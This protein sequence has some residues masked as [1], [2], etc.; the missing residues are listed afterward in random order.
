M[1]T[2]TGAAVIL[3]TNT[4]KTFAAA[5]FPF[6]DADVGDTL[7]AIKVTSLPA[8]TL[9][10]NGTPITS[11][12]SADIPV[13]S[14]ATL[15]YTPVTGYN[16]ADTFNFQVS[17]GVAFSADATMAVTITP[18]ILVRNGSFETPANQASPWSSFASPWVLTN[19]PAGSLS[20]QQIKA[21]AGGFFTSAPD[22]LW[23]ALINGDDCP[24]TAPLTQSLGVS[25]TAGDTLTV[26]FQSGRQLGQVGGAGVAYFD[27]A[28]TQYT[29]AFD[30][31]ALTA[32]AWQLT[33]LT[34]TITNSGNLT[35]G[36]YGTTGH[37]LNA[38]IDQISN[39][40]ATAGSGG[41]T[42]TITG[43]AT[44]AVFTTTY[45]TASAA[46][47]FAIAGTNLTA[48]ITATAPT[49]FEVSS[50]GTNYASTATFTQTGG[51]ASGTLDVRLA[52][53][54][55]V[56]GTHDG[57]TIVL[58]ST[59]ATS[60][61]VTTA[62]SG[63]VVSKATPTATLAVSNSPATYTGSAQAA[64]VGIT[65]SVPVGGSVTNISTGGA[66]SQTAAGTYAVTAD[67]VPADTANY[68][69]LTGLAAGDFVISPAAQNYT[70]WATTNGMTGGPSHVG[71]DGLTN[72]LVY[73]LNLKTNGGNGSPGT[74][75]G[76]SLSFAKRADAVTNNDVT[77]AIQISADLGVVDP[78]TT[79]TTGV[80][81]T[82]S[83]IS[84][85]MTTMGGTKHFARLVV[86]QK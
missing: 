55:T 2:S 57:Q 34:H 47:T 46:Q 56:S 58:S 78:W 71:H 30:T 21:V 43:A 59:G 86:T 44:A 14:I 85:D 12:P 50:D 20:Y 18:D 25:V 22:G 17:D 11:A 42:P 10:L 49:G 37:A 54:A 45:G 65:V 28:G 80:T 13:T 61:D 4:V 38:W 23:V 19:P 39:V 48:D 63:N 26:T 52:A 82:T 33:T 15:T 8:G 62:A 41:S 6:A 79:T 5:N 27:V 77:Y 76:H 84:I 83:A 53:T 64:T 40:S 60:V 31:S 7:Q 67:Y 16:G 32:G 68:N 73:A 70:S 66:A 29:T 36:F 72:L 75:T 1:P 81:E 35:L 3:R 24:I 51:S 69:S 9:T 74:L